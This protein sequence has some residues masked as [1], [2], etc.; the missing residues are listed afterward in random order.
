MNIFERV[1]RGNIMF[2]S[3]RGNLTDRDLWN[4]TKEE[5]DGMYSKLSAKLKKEE[6]ESLLDKKKQSTVD[7]ELRLEVIKYIVESKLR[8]EESAEK[9]V[10]TRERKAKLE[11]ALAEKRDGAINEMSEE[12]IEKELAELNGK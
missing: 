11:K 7:D 10:V 4:L 8:Q 9:A 12:D 3:V 2:Q 6:G 1:S 5:L